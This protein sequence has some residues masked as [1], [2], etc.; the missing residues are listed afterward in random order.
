MKDKW[1]F[2]RCALV[3]ALITQSL[4]IAFPPASPTAPSR[5]NLIQR[6]IS[7]SPLA[8]LNPMD[9]MIKIEAAGAVFAPPN[10]TQSNTVV[11]TCGDG[12][13]GAYG[14]LLAS[15][16]NQTVQLTLLARTPANVGAYFIDFA[17]GAGGSEVVMIQDWL[18]SQA[19]A[20]GNAQWSAT[21]VFDIPAGTRISSRC[22]W[23]T[24][25]ASPQMTVGIISYQRV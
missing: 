11:L 1:L 7:Q 22:L 9:D 18:I 2:V 14:E 6:V 19:T 15:T 17:K 20:A 12:I 5:S 13:D 3:L 8:M 4:D 23:V 24:T 16:S 25:G 10:T 21:V